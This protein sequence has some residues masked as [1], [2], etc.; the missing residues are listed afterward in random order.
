MRAPQSP[1]AVSIRIAAVVAATALL[2]GQASA[3]FGGFSIPSIPRAAS[4]AKTD[5][6][7]CPKGKSKSEIGRASCRER[8]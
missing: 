8:V 1:F 2:A 5:S 4:S 6:D 3:Q 7:G